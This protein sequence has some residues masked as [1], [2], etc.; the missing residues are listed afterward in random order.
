MDD[1]LRVFA[2]T[3]TEEILLSAEDKIRGLREDE[4]HEQIASRLHCIANEESAGMY[5]TL[6]EE[7]SDWEMQTWNTVERLASGIKGVEMIR[8]EAFT[9][10]NI[11]K[12]QF[13]NARGKTDV[14][15]IM[16]AIRPI[17]EEMPGLKI[18]VLEDVRFR[19]AQEFFEICPMYS[20]AVDGLAAGYRKKKVADDGTVIAEVTDHH[21]SHRTHIPCSSWQAYDQELH[22]TA[23]RYFLPDGLEVRN[24]MFSRIDDL[25]EYFSVGARV[26]APLIRANKGG[27]RVRAM[28]RLEND[29]DV[30]AGAPLNVTADEL[31]KLNFINPKRR[32]PI[33]A[34]HEDRA[35]MGFENLREGLYRMQRYI[36][37]DEERAELVYDYTVKQD[38]GEWKTINEPVSNSGARL[39]MLLDGVK[40]ALIIK[41][42][43][44]PN[45]NNLTLQKFTPVSNFP[46]CDDLYG[47]LNYVDSLHSDEEKKHLVSS[48]A[49]LKNHLAGLRSRTWVEQ[50]SEE[51]VEVDTGEND[52]HSIEVVTDVNKP[53]V[54]KCEGPFGGDETVGGGKTMMDIELIET[55]INWYISYF[56][57][58]PDKGNDRPTMY[59][60]QWNIRQQYE[61]F[62]TSNYISTA[63]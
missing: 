13:L 20:E 35:M 9:Y 49:A 10:V 31:A 19:T 16:D 15:A 27:R 18:F 41:S 2:P 51:V 6:N 50:D 24:M 4:P 61:K 46:L 33:D 63:A 47:F 14:Y 25:D 58:T 3:T 56:G 39:K 40:A 36:L 54:L 55:A 37:G 7:P 62:L 44:R 32:I 5:E 11:D 1:D 23:T 48:V 34:S 30:H 21:V 29:V 38:H 28:F 60:Q 8:C 42:P 26:F 17:A 57:K 43:Q 59:Q 22:G 45:E 12:T 53:K 52:V